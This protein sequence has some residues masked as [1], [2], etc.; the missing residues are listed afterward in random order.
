MINAKKYSTFFVL[1]NDKQFY[2]ADNISDEEIEKNARAG[3]TW[4][5]IYQMM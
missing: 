2:V 5:E 4:S 3:H 1:H